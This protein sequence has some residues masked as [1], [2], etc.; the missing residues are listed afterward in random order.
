VV[1]AAL[2]FSESQ[3][4]VTLDLPAGGVWRDVV[5]DR[6]YNLEAGANSFQLEAWKGLLLI[7]I[8]VHS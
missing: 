6:I 5:G 7:P 4:N 2:N 1:L 3:R 8:Y